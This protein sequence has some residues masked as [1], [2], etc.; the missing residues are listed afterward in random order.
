GE[1]QHIVVA[2]QIAAVGAQAL[3]PEVAL[4]EPMLLDHR[5]HGAIEHHDPLLEE[6]LEPRDPLT[7][8]RLVNRLDA[9]G[10]R[11]GAGRGGILPRIG[12]RRSCRMFRVLA[13]AHAMARWL[14]A[15]TPSA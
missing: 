15:R 6:T 13:D 1:T 12:S 9:E 8:S 11:R 14:V 7:P 3:S 10:H 4:L 2:A 5:T